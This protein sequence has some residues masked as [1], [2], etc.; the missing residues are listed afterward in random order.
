MK[1]EEQEKLLEKYLNELEDKININKN[2]VNVL[3]LPLI[4]EVY[5]HLKLNEDIDAEKLIKDIDNIYL[6]AEDI[7]NKN[8]T[9]IDKT[10]NK[11]IN[12][13]V[14]SLKDTF[15]TPLS[16]NFDVSLNMEV[17]KFKKYVINLYDMLK[18]AMYHKFN[19][20]LKKDILEAIST[21]SKGYETYNKAIKDLVNKLISGGT[22]TITHVT[23][24][25]KVI[26]YNVYTVIRRNILTSV[27]QLATG[28]N[29]LYQDE[30]NTDL[31]EVSAHTGARP[32]HQEWQGKIYTTNIDNT[33]YPY[34]SVTRYGAV[35]G[36][37]GANC[38]HTFFPFVEGLSKRSYTDAELNEMKK[39][40]GSI[41]IHNDT[42]KVPLYQ[43]VQKQRELE[44][45]VCKKKEIAQAY[46][47]IFNEN[48]NEYKKAYEDVKK[49]MDRYNKHCEI[50]GFYKEYN[51]LGNYIKW[52]K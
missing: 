29:K 19:E 32:A 10:I 27:N 7:T 48:S 2:N 50:N 30:L 47:K 28:I 46:L 11:D 23:S 14:Q 36:L 15:K 41:I 40:E 16:S 20:D 13:I 39:K 17:A 3:I 6:K 35:D 45:I 37:A 1:I 44:R 12:G 9:N 8:I 34:I 33:K 24:T 42:H 21:V 5:K 43:A 26:N 49:Y 52:K 51:R 25:G 38:R 4:K 22:N 31:V 18:N